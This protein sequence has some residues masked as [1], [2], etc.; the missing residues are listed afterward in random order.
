MRTPHRVEIFRYAALTQ[1]RDMANDVPDVIPGTIYVS[2]PF[3]G[4]RSRALGHPLPVELKTR[5]SREGSPLLHLGASR[6][7][8]AADLS[9]FL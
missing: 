7:F 2:R 9:C 1:P 6:R 8:S 3:T 5:A 4:E